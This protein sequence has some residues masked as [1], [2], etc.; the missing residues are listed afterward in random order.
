MLPVGLIL[1]LA[2]EAWF[3]TSPP[4]T[5]MGVLLAPCTRRVPQIGVLPVFSDFVFSMNQ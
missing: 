5:R 2:K 1:F 3:H 4:D